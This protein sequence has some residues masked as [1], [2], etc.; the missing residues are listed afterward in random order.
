MSTIY[1]I[2]EAIDLLR[3]ELAQYDL[4]QDTV[5][6]FWQSAPKPYTYFSTIPVDVCK[7]IA[8]HIPMRVIDLKPY[9]DNAKI[10]KQQFMEKYVVRPGQDTKL[11][12]GDLDAGKIK[13]DYPDLNRDTWCGLF[14]KCVSSTMHIKTHDAT[15]RWEYAGNAFMRMEYNYCTL[16]PSTD[17][18]NHIN[19]FY[20]HFHIY[21][22]LPCGLAFVVLKSS[23]DRNDYQSRNIY[24]L[25]DF[26]TKKLPQT[27]NWIQV[28]TSHLPWACYLNDLGEWIESDCSS[29][30][31]SELHGSFT[32]V[33]P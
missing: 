32:R 25:A 28:S 16:Y 27:E 30:V 21:R 13:E 2:R 9:F 24:Y 22:V 3:P 20:R 11:Q 10:M 26:S 17:T 15:E 4:L 18:E 19:Y 29:V 6:S 5:V 33:Y 8:A 7:I 12:V 31:W 14:V 1:S 23:F